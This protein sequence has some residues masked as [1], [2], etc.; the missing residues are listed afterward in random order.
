MVKYRKM[1]R[2]KKEAPEGMGW[3]ESE[4]K[5]KWTSSQASLSLEEAGDAPVNVLDTVYPHLSTGGGT[6]Q[7]SEH[8]LR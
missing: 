7:G 3:G 4:D 6:K 8:H 2:G 1:S 5:A